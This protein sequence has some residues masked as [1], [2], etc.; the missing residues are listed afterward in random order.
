MFASSSRGRFGARNVQERERAKLRT[1][2]KD[3]RVETTQ[4]LVA[5]P[6]SG[7]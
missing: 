4:T 1:Q 2:I 7:P 6:C 3:A 5:D